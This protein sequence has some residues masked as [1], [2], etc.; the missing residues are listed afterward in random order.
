MELKVN[1][2]GPGVLECILLGGGTVASCL[3]ATG[4]HQPLMS[5]RCYEVAEGAVAV[6][7]NAGDGLWEV[8]GRGRP[9]RC[10]A[11]LGGG[12]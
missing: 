8:H 9:V 3:L 11:I 12:G 1:R 2:H 10:E 5:V 6:A 4:R 7:R